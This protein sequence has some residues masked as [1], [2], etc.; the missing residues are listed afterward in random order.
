MP[1][2]ATARAKEALEEFNKKVEQIR[3]KIHEAVSQA[4][5]DLS[6]EALEK[7]DSSASPS[8]KPTTP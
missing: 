8:K 2:A 1:N 6:S 7:P 5:Q 3:Q 4:Q